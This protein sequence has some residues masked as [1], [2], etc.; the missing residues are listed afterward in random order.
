V[1]ALALVPIALSSGETML[2]ATTTGWL[3][4]VGLALVC[5]TAGQ[6]LIAYAMAHLPA[7]FS[8]VS[9]LLQPVLAALYAWALLGETVGALQLAGGMVILLGICVA[10]RGSAGASP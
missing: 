7:S 1:C 2:P 9:L 6:S 8:A 4:L 3:T 10:R 5:Q